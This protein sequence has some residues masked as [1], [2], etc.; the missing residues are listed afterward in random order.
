MNLKTQLEGF[1]GAF[2]ELETAA[3]KLEN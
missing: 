2:T 3:R 1:A